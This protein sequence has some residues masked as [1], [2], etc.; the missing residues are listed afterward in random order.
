[1]N[2]EHSDP[3]LRDQQVNELIAAYLQAAQ[4]GKPP[5]RQVLLA[6]HP[7]LADDL[8]SFFADRDR[9]ECL[10][11]PL[12]ALAPQPHGDETVTL[13]AHQPSLPPG[14]QV[15]YF[16]DYELLEE[17]GR[18]GMGVVYKAR[19]S[20]L[21]RL[22]ALKMILAGPL[23]SAADRQRFRIE[24]ENAARLDHPNIVPIYE[25]GEHEGQH[26]FSMKLVEGGSLT[27]AVSSGQWA[28][29][30]K[31]AQ[32]WV[33]RLT[34]TVARAVHYAHQRGVLHR[35]LKP[36]NVQ[37]DQDGQP[38][39][40]DFGLAKRVEGG[41][42][43]TQSGELLGT[44]SYMAPEQAAGR[45]GMTTAVDVYG[46]GAILYELLAGRPPFRAATPLET[47][48]QVLE[49][50][51][52]PPRSYAPEVDRDLET[53][54]LKCLEKDPSRRYASAEAL[55]L[56]LE[57]WLAG[58]PIHARRTSTWER[59]RKWARRKPATAAL[60][61]VSVLAALSLLVGGIW[62]AARLRERLWRS[63]YEQARAE[64]LAG[65]RSRALELIAEAAHMR[66]SDDL[67]QEAIQTLTMPA[68]QLLH[69]FPV[70]VASC[71]R[72]SPDGSR[73]AV[74]GQFSAWPNDSTGPASQ[75]THGIQI[76]AMPSGRPL[77]Q[78]SRASSTLALSPDGTRV[79]YRGTNELLHIWELA[80]GRDEVLYTVS[81]P[82]V[83]RSDEQLP[84]FLFSP[85]GARLLSTHQDGARLWDLRNLALEPRSLPGDPLGFRSNSEILTREGGRLKR[86]DLATGRETFLSPGEAEPVAVSADGRVAALREKRSMVP[87]SNGPTESR[88]QQ[89]RVMLQDLAAG[90]PLPSPPVLGTV[91]RL[92]LSPDGNLLAFRDTEDL[93]MV[94]IWDT[95]RG[96]YRKSL[97]GLAAS[98]R[99]VFERAAFSPDGAWLAAEAG[100]N[101]VRVWDIE[102]GREVAA[103][104]DNRAPVWSPKSRLLATTGAGVVRLE[105]GALVSSGLLTAVNVW[106]VTRLAPGYALPAPVQTLSFRHDGKQLAAGNTLWDVEGDVSLRSLRPVPTTLPGGRAV[107]AG[108]DELWAAEFQPE[109]GVRNQWHLRLWQVAPTRRELTLPNVGLDFARAFA[110]HPDGTCLVKTR[111]TPSQVDDLELWDI[112]T[113]KPL[114]SWNAQP[115]GDQIK[116]LAFSPD[117]RLVASAGNNRTKLWD[118]TTGQLLHRLQF[119]PYSGGHH[120]VAFSPDGTLLFVG[121]AKGTGEVFDNNSQVPTRVDGRSVIG[122]AEVA[123]GKE[124]ANWKGH[125]G[126]V[127]SLAVRAD[128]RLLASGGEDRTIRLWDIPSG[129]ELARWEAHEGRVTALAFHPDGRTLVSGDS[130]GGLRVWN[131]GPLREQLRILDLGWDE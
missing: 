36:A 64:R 42:A 44:P 19:Q 102:T 98:P 13:A 16:G 70:G 66:R 46:L 73:L 35:D 122:I 104:R 55:A 9:F 84:P 8:A 33:A 90:K 49:R 50:E 80:T 67:R 96:Q 101:I 2:Q 109:S 87:A 39:V 129:R 85:D 10:A 112:A 40:T 81:N 79:V 123:T 28:V 89:A 75:G 100:H 83:Y 25:V 5:D 105:N 114:A 41:P 21:N 3:V 131:L 118:A 52:A 53:I 38:Y 121:S 119:D 27:Q 54:C 4:A 37:L 128:G 51:P 48:L 32:Q 127:L 117:G 34:V 23:A 65:D 99:G 92:H 11:A 62:S 63:L 77:A 97:T 12:R 30:S 110:F 24:A 108:P 58:E 56:D 103:L 71:V 17:L 18:G 57:R 61:V 76:W 107:F 31:E 26:Y 14:T 45:K 43:L 82:A 69:H 111:G 106:D 59:A 78:R 124:L 113:G 86:R 116:A 60:F 15:R 29:G 130:D 72:F 68:V 91:E 120:C 7:D 115:S 95:A 125:D 20:S 6:R 94:R 93:H 22:V 88:P 126:V 47:I 74:G 1:M